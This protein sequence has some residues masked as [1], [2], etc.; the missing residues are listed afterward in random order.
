MGVNLGVD[1]TLQDAKTFKEKCDY[2]WPTR[3]ATACSLRVAQA[4]LASGKPGR[5]P[6]ERYG[7][8]S[9]KVE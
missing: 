9:S 3:D 5:K 8:L 1:T 4:K 7:Y 6:D 2:V